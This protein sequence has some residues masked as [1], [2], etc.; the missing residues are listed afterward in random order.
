M[1]LLFFDVETT[2]PNAN[3]DRIVELGIKVVQQDGKVILNKSKRYNPE[4]KIQAEATKVHGIKYSD[5]K[6]CPV[7]AEDARK[8]AK[9]FKDKIIAGYNIMVFDIPILMNEFDRA[10]VELELSGKYIDSFKIEQKLSSKSLS[11]VYK[12]YT[13]KDL[14]D[15]H[16]AEADLNATHE[17]LE[18]QME[19]IAKMADMKPDMFENLYTLSG[20]KDIVD[21]YSKFRR[22]DDGYLI[23]KFG[24]HKDKRVVD[25]IGYA[26]WMLS[27]KPPFPS[28]IQNLLR[29]EKRKLTQGLFTKKEPA[30]NKGFGGPAKKTAAKSSTGKGF[31]HEKPGQETSPKGQWQPV[32]TDAMNEAI[33]DLPF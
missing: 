8:L 25:E 17:V 3:E 27:V 26:D 28:Q 30:E 2:G 32:Y 11:N 1:D 18:F 12:S 6:D 7:F 14:E 4:M 33:D 19:K 21:F 10:G 22:D 9:L 5:I 31:M 20:T 23:Y 29:E 15:A 24:K 16:T 13:G